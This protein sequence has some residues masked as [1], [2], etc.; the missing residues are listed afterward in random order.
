MHQFTILPEK[1]ANLW[2]RLPVDFRFDHGLMLCWLVFLKACG[3]SEQTLKGLES[4]APTHVK[5]WKWRRLLTARYWNFNVLIYWLA[6]QVVKILPKPKDGVYYLIFDSSHKDKRGKQNPYN[7]K[8]KIWTK[9][10][11]FFG[12]KF[13]VALLHWGNYRIPLGFRLIETKK[14]KD[15]K[16]EGILFQEMMTSFEIPSFV[17]TL[18]IL[19]DSGFASKNNFKFL[20]DLSKEYKERGIKLIYIFALPRSWKFENGKHVRDLINHLPSFYYQKE[21]VISLSNTFKKKAYWV[22]KKQDSLNEI[23]QVTLILSKKWR[24]LGPKSVK[25]LVTNELEI[26]EEGMLDSY[27]R[28][29]Y[30]EVF[31]REIKSGLGLGREQLTVDKIRVANGVSI[32][33]MSYLLILWAMGSKINP[34]KSWSI[35]SLRQ[36]FQSEILEEHYEHQTKKIIS[37]Y[38]KAA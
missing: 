9:K 3:L 22:Y 18:K 34:T 36:L 15:Y 14:S 12:M 8:G 33:F 30:I 32:S 19:A 5:E 27:Q 31:N 25:I 6:M 7:Q 24:N 1:I 21:K 37:R 23:G 10:H 28:R 20:N 35:F 4:R 29:F 26:E 11:W 16:K 2:R 17:K 38:K 13:L